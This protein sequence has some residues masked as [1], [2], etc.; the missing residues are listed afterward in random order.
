MAGALKKH[1]GDAVARIYGFNALGAMAGSLVGP[2]C[3]VPAFGIR[4]SLLVTF[5]VNVAIVTVALLLSR[6]ESAGEAV[7]RRVA[8]AEL[9]WSLA[10]F[11]AGAVALGAETTWLRM[12]AMVIVNGP[13]LFAITLAVFLGAYAVGSL[14][15]HPILSRRCLPQTESAWVQIAVAVSLLATVPLFRFLPNLHAAILSTFSP[16][17]LAFSVSFFEIVAVVAI[18]FLP[19]L[20]MGVV[21]PA[22]A[23]VTSATGSLYFW[24]NIGS[25]FGI[26]VFGLFV[27][28]YAGL[29]GSLMILV[30][31]S[32]LVGVWLLPRSTRVR[33]AT[34]ASCVAALALWATLPP[35]AQTTGTVRRLPN[36]TY[37]EFKD[38][39]L[40]NKILRYHEGRT[41]TITIRESLSD[42]GV[43]RLRRVYVDEQRVAATDPDAIVD[44]KMLAHLP[45][46]LHPH[47]QRALSVGYGSG[48]TSW[49]LTT[50]NLQARTVEIEGEVLRSAQLFPYRTVWDMPNF[51]AIHNDAR[52]HLQTTDERYDFISTDVTNLQYNQNS[53]L[54]TVEY[55]KMMRDRLTGDGIACAW[56]PM[57]SISPESFRTLLAT[58][59][60]VYPHASLWLMNEMPTY[61]GILIGTKGPLK[62]DMARMAAAMENPAVRGDLA[63]IGI[64]HPYQ[65]ADDLLLDEGGMRAFTAGAPLH[66][67]DDPV[68]EHS[69]SYHNYL[70][71]NHF[72]DNLL[73]TLRYR[74]ATPGELVTGL[75]PKERADFDRAWAA[76]TDWYQAIASM[77]ELKVAGDLATQQRLVRDVKYFANQAMQAYP[78]VHSWQSL[79][80]QIM[81]GGAAMRR[82]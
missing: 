28:P 33:L 29:T 73:G 20:A 39:G 40:Q 36:G 9:S 57:S 49:S 14:V 75:S 24:G 42:D 79:Y 46:M 27:I 25:L 59:Q 2:L 30:A 4:T 54:Y 21:F 69:A 12:L 7:G 60:H 78:V 23:R 17:N 43:T 71:Y 61:F 53:T 52:D 26:I 77:S 11:A 63:T 18:V 41:S 70:Y 82:L 80:A 22:M 15:V 32:S 6:Q 64:D 58:F 37:G 13:L 55:F 31:L 16:G 47:P 45:A 48:G 56:I 8:R 50:H 19:A 81:N 44:S 10:Y 67:D 1:S 34:V 66:T 35:F 38:G 72:V 5:L 74:P 3:M 65:V 76:S 51:K 62:I 68:L